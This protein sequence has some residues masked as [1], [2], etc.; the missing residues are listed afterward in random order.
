MKKITKMNEAAWVLGIIFCSLGVALCTKANFG[1]S[2]IAAMPY[3]IHIKMISF[4]SWYSQGTSEYIWQG[5]LLVIMCLS[6]RK[7]KIKYLLS[8]AAAVIFGFAVDMWLGILGGNG[9][10]ESMAVRVIAF[11]IGESVTAL[12]VA[13]YFRTDMPLQ[14]YELFVVEIAD[15]YKL[16][17]N[18]V[19]FCN[20][21]AMLIL[22]VAA[23]L[24]LNKSFAGLGVGTVII[25]LVN[26]YL[27]KKFGELLDKI[28]VFDARFDKFIKA[29]SL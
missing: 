4:F 2:M 23:A 13:F 24:L 21:A 9:A 15:T 7:F 3:I 28:F 29:V 17:R 1:L 6:V 10:Y 8:F 22:S 12:A 5:I 25:T 18:K 19:K 27:I 20:D 14:M 26:A 11:I 16:D